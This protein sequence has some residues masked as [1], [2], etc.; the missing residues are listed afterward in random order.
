MMPE[1]GNRL[2][3]KIMQK[4]ANALLCKAALTHSD[5]STIGYSTRCGASSGGLR[6][7]AAPSA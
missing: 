7:D 1:S 3:Q 2:L 6:H 4:P 5:F